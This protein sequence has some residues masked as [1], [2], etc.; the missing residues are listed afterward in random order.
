MHLLF[1]SH[2]GF[3]INTNILETNVLNLAVV[4]AF[5][6]VYVGD[7]F[8]EVLAKRRDRVLKTINNAE[9]KYQ[10]ALFALEQA[11]LKFIQAKYKATSIRSNSRI[12]LQ[13]LNLSLFKQAHDEQ[14][15]QKKK[16]YKKRI[17]AEKKVNAYIYQNF[18]INIFEVAP[19]LFWEDCGNIRLQKYVSYFLLTTLMYRLVER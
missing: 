19:V 1:L 4:I 18:I 6:Y 17:L 10:E 2:T 14:K 13:R 3:G 9:E 15:G 16:E 12:V 11:K 5:V 8:S 7:V